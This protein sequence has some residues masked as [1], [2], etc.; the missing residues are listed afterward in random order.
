[1][2]TSKAFAQYYLRVIMRASGFS[3]TEIAEALK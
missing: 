1:M 3:E 2:K